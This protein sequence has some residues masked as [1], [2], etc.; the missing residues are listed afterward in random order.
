MHGNLNNLTTQMKGQAGARKM[1]QL[2]GL[3]LVK[4]VLDLEFYYQ[5]VLHVF[6]VKIGGDRLKKEQKE[7]IEQIE[8]QGGK[9]YEIRD[10]ENFKEI[11]KNIVK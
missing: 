3:G 9:G 5:G 4:G 11:I 7:F 8:S 10:L 6:D 2:K 1:A